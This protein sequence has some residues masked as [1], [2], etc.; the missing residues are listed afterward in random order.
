MRF[1]STKLNALQRQNEELK[2]EIQLF[3]VG[4]NTVLKHMDCSIRKFSIMPVT[5]SR[6][7]RI[8]DSNSNNRSGNSGTQ[9]S[10][11]SRTNIGGSNVQGHGS[12][13]ESTLSPSQR[14]LNM[15][16]TEWEFGVGGRKAAKLFNNEERGRVR[17]QYSLRKNF[18]DLC[19]QMIRSGHTTETAV[20]K[21]YEVYSNTRSIT[22]ILRLIRRDK[23]EGG[24]PS[25]R[26]S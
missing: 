23:K 15:L 9:S 12:S 13:Y 18:W 6:G 21:I 22:D 8:E 24:H 5:R 11:T 3:K 17:F 4:T 16:G 2:N 14:T 25:L 19:G 26:Y 1:M 7:N 10:T 20:D